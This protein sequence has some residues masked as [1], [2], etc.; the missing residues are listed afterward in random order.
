MVQISV[1]QRPKKKMIRS[2]Y[3]FGIDASL[4]K[5]GMFLCQGR[6]VRALFIGV[7]EFSSIFFSFGEG[8]ACHPEMPGGKQGLGRSVPGCFSLS[9]LAISGSRQGLVVTELLKNG[10][11][12]R[13]SFS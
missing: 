3:R 7:P 5:F 1:V 9:I 10:D 2:L 11:V 6:K 8:G 12:A 4:P 13:H